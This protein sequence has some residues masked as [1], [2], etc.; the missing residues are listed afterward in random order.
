LANACGRLDAMSQPPRH[1]DDDRAHRE[2]ARGVA[3][4]RSWL[5]RFVDEFGWRA[6]AIPILAV[7]TALCVGNLVSTPSDA[8]SQAPTTVTASPSTTPAGPTPDWGESS[9]ATPSGSASASST[10]PAGTHPSTTVP[11]SAPVSSSATG[12]PTRSGAAPSKA[13]SSSAPTSSSPPADPAALPPGP[14][15]PERG[16]D[17]YSVVPGTSPTVGSG[18]LHRYEVEVEN[19]MS[20]IDAEE[21]ADDVVATLSDPRSWIHGGVSLQRVDSGKAD[22][23]IIL[24]SS[25]TIREKCGYDIKVETSCYTSGIVY[26]NASRWVRG[27]YAYNG[28]LA[29]YR[30]YMINHEVGHALGHGHMACPANGA[31]APLMM[32]QTLGLTTKGVGTC[33]AN[34]WP[35]VDGKLIS[36]PPIKGF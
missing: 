4:S 13:S 3:D 9:T 35:Y 5:T 28:D 26:I 1:P 27:A 18:P 8:S 22:F 25:L 11:A 12:A 7:V 33:K 10:P 34:P 14:A 20:G 32:E 16:S 15:Y 6:Y 31:L 24:I 29:E 23:R 21:F 30:Q 2:R 36:G 19:D 17:T